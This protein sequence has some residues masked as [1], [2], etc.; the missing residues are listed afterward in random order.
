M[1]TQ[2]WLFDLFWLV[3][4]VEGVAALFAFLRMDR[5]VRL[6]VPAD[7]LAAFALLSHY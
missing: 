3:I 6:T 7:F 4:Q 1:L 5:Y 2:T